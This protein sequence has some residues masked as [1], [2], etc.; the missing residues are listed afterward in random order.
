MLI[1]V[2]LCWDVFCVLGIIALIW[3][4]QLQKEQESEIQVVQVVYFRAW[5][6][7]LWKQ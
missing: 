3:G 1:L 2:G 6:K 4:L 5:S 7:W